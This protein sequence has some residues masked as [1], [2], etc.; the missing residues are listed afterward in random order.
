MAFVDFSPYRQDIEALLRFLRN[1]RRGR[2]VGYNEEEEE[3]GHG[4]E[5]GDYEG[6]LPF[7]ID[8]YYPSINISII[9]ANN[10]TQEYT[11]HNL[12]ILHGETLVDAFLRLWRDPD[13]SFK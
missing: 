5:G 11:M 2:I 10:L 3:G 9:I 1:R 12:T 8:D 7:E 13:V 4:G 6:Y